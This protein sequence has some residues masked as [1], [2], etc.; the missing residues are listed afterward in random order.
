MNE[1]NK[2]GLARVH[3]QSLSTSSPMEPHLQ[4]GATKRVDLAPHAQ[5]AYL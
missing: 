2:A 1:A 5:H 3:A 4:H